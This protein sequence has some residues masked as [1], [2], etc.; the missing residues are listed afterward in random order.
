MDETLPEPSVLL[1]DHGY[2]SD[3][4]RKTMEEWNAVTI[5]PMPESRKLRSGFARPR[6]TLRNLGERRSMKPKTVCHPANRYAKTVVV[7]PG[8]IGIRSIRPRLRHLSP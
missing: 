3:N 8:L 5:V 1:V 7:F 6:Q 4:V 2:G